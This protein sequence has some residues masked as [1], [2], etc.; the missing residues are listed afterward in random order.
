MKELAALLVLLFVISI[1]PSFCAGLECK[2]GTAHR[3]PNNY[4]DEHIYNN[5]TCPADA[6][7]CVAA[8]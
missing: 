4:T 7:Y 5:S 1:H 8:T 2:K 3:G 6:I